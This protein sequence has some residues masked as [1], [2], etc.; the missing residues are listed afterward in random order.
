M[1]KII[2]TLLIIISSSVINAQH[3]K[4]ELQETILSHDKKFWEAYNQCDLESF[5]QFIAEDFEFYHD[6]GGLTKGGTKMMSLVKQNLCDPSNPRVRR[7]VVQGSVKVYPL[8]NYGAIISGEHQFYVTS[9]GQEERL[10]EIAKFTHVWHKKDNSWQMTRVLSFDHQQPSGNTEN[11]SVNISKD[12][13]E[14]YTGT[15]NAP[16]TGN[17]VI[18][19]NDNQLRLQAGKMDMMLKAKENNIFF[20]ETAPLTFEFKENSESGRMEMTVREN[21][22]VVEIATIDN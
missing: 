13:L 9:S 18:S 22:K 17:V 10:T 1:K 20:S 6:K 21:N 12:I 7:E 11:K 8:N 16:K 2:L 3:N 4:N 14:Q 15:Y 5:G 19:V